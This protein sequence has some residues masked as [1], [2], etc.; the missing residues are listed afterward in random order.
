MFHKLAAVLRHRLLLTF[1]WEVHTELSH[2]DE[3]AP[4]SI[5]RLRVN[6][7]IDP[8]RILCALFAFGIAVRY[9]K[10]RIKK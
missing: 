2:A 10:K 7:R 8:L 6:K 5:F 4:N 9:F 3:D 1:R